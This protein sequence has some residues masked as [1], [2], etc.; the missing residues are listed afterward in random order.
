MSN[1]TLKILPALMVAITAI[2]LS[3]PVRAGVINNIVLTENSDTSLTAT[4]NGSTSGVTVSSGVHSWV[5]TFPATVSFNDI[6][7]VWVEPENS[8][9]VNAVEFLGGNVAQVL[10]EATTGIP[11]VPNGTTITNV[12]TDSSNGGSISVTFFDNGDTTRTPDTGTA[13]SL[14]GLSLMG[15]A[16]LRRKFVLS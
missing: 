8:G 5:I 15:L 12:G 3:Q 1:S 9:E 4:Y 7:V 11:S 2:L 6:F 10:S 14:F 13:L 16:L